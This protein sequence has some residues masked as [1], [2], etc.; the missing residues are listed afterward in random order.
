MW[1]QLAIVMDVG[2]LGFRELQT[3]NM[4]IL[5]KMVAITFTELESLW[6]PPLKGMYFPNS[7]FIDAIKG[8]RALWGWSS[9]LVSRYVL[10]Q[11]G[12]RKLNVGSTIKIFQG[13]WIHT[14]SSFRSNP[15]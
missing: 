1:E 11:E 12:L 3:F 6:V 13:P 9:L 10:K 15:A 8:G 2:G 4:T 5:T 14:K 7:D